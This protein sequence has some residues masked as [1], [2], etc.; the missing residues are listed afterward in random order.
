MIALGAGE[1][2]LFATINAEVGPVTIFD[3][4]IGAFH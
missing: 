3:T 1:F 4:A 2:Q